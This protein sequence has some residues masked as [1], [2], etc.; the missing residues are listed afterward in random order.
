MSATCTI[1]IADTDD[2]SDRNMAET[3][4]SCAAPLAARE[5][6]LTGSSTTHEH[7]ETVVLT[8]QKAV[9][10]SIFPDTSFCI[11]AP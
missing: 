10:G 3:A 7:N 8:T 5:P 4:A 9:N 6:K 11:A 1:V 2:F